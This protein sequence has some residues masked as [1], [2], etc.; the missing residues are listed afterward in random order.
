MK[1][2]LLFFAAAVTLALTALSGTLL[3]NA[4]AQ[5]RGPTRV[6]EEPALDKPLAKE[7]PR[8]QLDPEWLN[9]QT[10]TMPTDAHV[11]APLDPVYGASEATY[12]QLTGEQELHYE[13]RLDPD[14]LG[15][16]LPTRTTALSYPGS[17][18]P[19]AKL[20]ELDAPPILDGDKLY[21][22]IGPDDR[23][24]ITNTTAFPWRTMTKL[25]ITF[26][27]GARGGCSGALIAAKYVLTAGHC[28]HSSSNGGWASRIEVVPGLNGTY[29]PYGAAFSTRLRSYTGWTQNR[30]SNYDF[31]L[32]TLDRSIGNSTGW[33]GYAYIPTINGV[34][35]NLAGYPGDRDG[36]TGLYYHSGPIRSS[37]TY[38]VT[39]TIDTAG[40]QSGSSVY[41]L[42][43][44]Q[45]HV[46]AVHTNGG[47]TSNSGTRITSQRFSDLQA[48]IASGN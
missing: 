6:I 13:A 14:L 11:G 35:G 37:T 23:S 25:F 45:R 12:D 1:R 4:A 18:G 40:G 15:R 24:K 26:P 41:R 36:G 3:F 9:V 38:R 34:T 31:A 5:R 47:T 39:Y 43:N 7:D 19:D 20:E 33:L 28:V 8:A 32:I 16:N 22:V 44:G 2:K 30:D 48:W 27:N 10:L 46:F 42:L 17:I 21:S 29:R